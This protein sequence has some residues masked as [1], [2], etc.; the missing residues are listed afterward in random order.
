MQPDDASPPT[1]RLQAAE[2]FLENSPAEG[3]ELR[4]GGGLVL[5]FG[6][7]WRSWFVGLSARLAAVGSSVAEVVLR[8][9]GTSDRVYFL[10]PLSCL[11]LGSLLG[12]GFPL[13]RLHQVLR[14]SVPMH[15]RR[16][17]QLRDCAN[18]PGNILD[19]SSAP[20]ELLY[21]ALFYASLRFALLGYAFNYFVLHCS[22]QCAFC[23]HVSCTQAC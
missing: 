5:V 10:L 2:L 9:L 23:D 12:S 22:V 19:G 20:L 15:V 14:S 11:F 13:S 21:A 1:R 8:P 3:A 4:T 17:L 16:A 7:S 18:P 6:S